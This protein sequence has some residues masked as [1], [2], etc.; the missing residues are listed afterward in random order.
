MSKNKT[1]VLSNDHT[2]LAL[3]SHLRSLSSIDDDQHVSKFKKVPEGIEVQIT[4][5]KHD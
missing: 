3:T 2:C 4:K 5:E 1:L